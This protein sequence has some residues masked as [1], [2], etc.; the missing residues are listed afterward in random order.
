[1]SVLL[2]GGDLPAALA[3]GTARGAACVRHAGAF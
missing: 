1:M 3:A 2:N